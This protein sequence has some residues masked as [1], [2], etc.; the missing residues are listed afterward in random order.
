MTHRDHFI[1]SISSSSESATKWPLCF[2]TS[3]EK[4]LYKMDKNRLLQHSPRSCPPEG[5][6]QNRLDS[7]FQ[8]VRNPR[9][10]TFNPVFH[11]I[12]MDLRCKNPHIVM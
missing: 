7:S 10:S 1:F 2:G 5:R 4:I 12:L 8:P 6:I 3:Y 11:L 9:I